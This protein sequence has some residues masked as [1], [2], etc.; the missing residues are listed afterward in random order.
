MTAL[1][2][3]STAHGV[4]V[5]RAERRLNMVSAPRLLGAVRSM[6]ASGQAR[7]VV[8]LSATEF[9]DSSGL[10]AV[11]SS[12]KKAREAGGDIKL[13]GAGEQVQMVLEL[14]NLARVLQ[15][16]PTVDDAARMFECD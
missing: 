5:V 9:I 13:S 8:D 16:L 6:I 10:G 11:I 14:T 1:D 7:I 3:S 4:A 2:V 15:P 12:L